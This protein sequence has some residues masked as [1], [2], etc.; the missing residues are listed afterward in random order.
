[1]Q[2]PPPEPD[3]RTP[4]EMPPPSGPPATTVATAN[5]PP[6]PTARAKVRWLSTIV[7]AAVLGVVVFG[8]YV[9]AGALSQPAGPPVTVAGVVRVQPLSGW[10]VAGRFASPPGARLSRGSGNLDFA[11]LPFNG[12]SLDLVREYVN[13]V[14][15]PGAQQLSVSKEAEP[16]T[17]RSG[18]AGVRIRYIG[19]F[20]RA[21]SSI[22]GEVTAIVSPQGVGAIFD[23]W[24]PEGLLQYVIDDIDTM[25]D[26]AAIG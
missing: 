17:L 1:M 22:E 6:V 9:A 21:Q 3:P 23:A 18:L 20:G 14:L 4:A 15:E 11:A 8:G 26:R 5:P 2:T 10:E 16:V 24:S 19:S 13:Q 25:I 7:L 12:S